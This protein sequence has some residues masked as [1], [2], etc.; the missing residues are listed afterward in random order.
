MAAT[1]YVLSVL[2]DEKVVSVLQDNMFLHNWCE[3]KILHLLNS[4]SAFYLKTAQ[5]LFFFHFQFS[6]CSF[7]AYAGSVSLHN[8]T[9]ESDCQSGIFTAE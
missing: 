4:V 1:R 8:K 2:E 6:V 7:P 9:H 3:M 5:M